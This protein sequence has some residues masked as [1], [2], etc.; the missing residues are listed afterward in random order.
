M[1]LITE[2]KEDDSE[3]DKRI[4]C[5]RDLLKANEEYHKAKSKRNVNLTSTDPHFA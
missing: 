5:T 4:E 2:E 1:K 3:R